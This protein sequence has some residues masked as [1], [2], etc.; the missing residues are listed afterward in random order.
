MEDAAWRA[1]ATA[2]GEK[3]GYVRTRRHTCVKLSSTPLGLIT[4]VSPPR[5]DIVH[6]DGIFAENWLIP[7][8]TNV[9]VN[10]GESRPYLPKAYECDPFHENIFERIVI[11]LILLQS[12]FKGIV[13]YLI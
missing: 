3:G 11:C 8:G 5:C 13:I 6:H 4:F 2:E 7:M 10:S 12:K 1:R 9:A